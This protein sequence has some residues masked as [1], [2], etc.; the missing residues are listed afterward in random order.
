MNNAFVTGLTVFSGT[1]Q[2]WCIIQTENGN[3]EIFCI[4]ILLNITVKINEQKYVMIAGTNFMTMVL[5][6]KDAK[7]QFFFSFCGK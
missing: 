3:F 7:T 2:G 1:H 5:M 6:Q 4:C